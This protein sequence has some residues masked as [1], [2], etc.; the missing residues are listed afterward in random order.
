MKG[1]RA[2]RGFFDHLDRTGLKMSLHGQAVR[3]MTKIM[4]QSRPKATTTLEPCR[5][6]STPS[7]GGFS[8]ARCL[9]DELGRVIGN[10]G[11]AIRWFES[12]KRVQQDEEHVFVCARRHELGSSGRKLP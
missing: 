9:T 11:S 5:I 2:W 4:H 7:P 8:C 10:A 3:L 6:C 1:G 12:F